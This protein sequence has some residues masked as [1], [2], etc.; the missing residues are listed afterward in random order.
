MKH[1]RGMIGSSFLN[2]LLFIGLLFIVGI[3]RAAEV[4]DLPN[5][6]KLVNDF[7]GILTSEEVGELESSLLAYRDTTSNEIAIVIE[8]TIGD[9]DVFTYAQ[10]LFTK[11]KIGTKENN[12]GALLLIVMDQRKAWIHVGNGLEPVLTDGRC[13]E[14]VRQII[15]PS[16]K[17]EQYFEG[18]KGALRAMIGYIG[19]EFSLKPKLNPEYTPKSFVIP[20]IIFL[21]FIGLAFYS[22]YRTEKKIRN[23]MLAYGITY[24]AARK[25]LGLDRPSSAGGGGWGGF[26]GG[27]GSW[28]G[29]GGG[30]GFGGF[31]GGSSGGGGG[32][33][34]W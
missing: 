21:L 33:G 29:G 3:A 14:I 34:S 19:G 2:K 31:G 17:Q 15:T 27:G 7:A 12:N 25:L 28:G 32:G 8:S 18:I 30:G 5:P 20:I 10:E 1:M 11:W 13:G 16:F 24:L 23:T 4:R 22:N 6:P 9:F 26:I